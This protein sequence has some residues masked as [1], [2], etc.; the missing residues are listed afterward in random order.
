MGIFLLWLIL[1]FVVGAVASSNG[2]SFVGYLLLSL[3]LSPLIGLIVLLISSI[4]SPAHKQVAQQSQS[5]PEPLRYTYAST[6]KSVTCRNC[7]KEFTEDYSSCP[8]CGAQK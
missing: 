7:G 8:H 2:R 3:L 6:L 4:N 5:E 1:A